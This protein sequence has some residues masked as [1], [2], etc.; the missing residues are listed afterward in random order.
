MKLLNRCVAGA[1]LALVI[2]TAQ[3]QP[4][5]QDFIP[6]QVGASPH[7][8][9]TAAVPTATEAANAAA[10]SAAAQRLETA[11]TALREATTTVEELSLQ[12]RLLGAAT[13]LLVLA[14]VGLLRRGNPP[15]VLARPEAT[16]AALAA[17]AEQASQLE[18]LQQK[19]SKLQAAHNAL[20][21]QSEAW[22]QQLAAAGK[23][24]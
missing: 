22:R 8:A 12:R 17:T 3:A 18:Y 2:T 21:V 20:L 24:G 1:I 4:G 19:H 7:P 14:V 15:P 23:I 11:E 16:A 5:S 10:T 13:G 9:G 6:A